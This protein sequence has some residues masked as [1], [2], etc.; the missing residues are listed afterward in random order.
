MTM[1]C[2]SGK[3]HGKNYVEILAL[4]VVDD[5][6]T[7]C[8]SGYKAAR[9][10]SFINANTA[11][12]KLQFGPRKCHILHVGKKHEDTKKLHTMWKTGKCRKCKV[13]MQ[14]RSHMKRHIMENMLCLLRV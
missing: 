10:N 2:L 12:K 13:S 5:L 1:A 7:V 14:E 6:L 4:G 3:G 8:E 11:I 9:M